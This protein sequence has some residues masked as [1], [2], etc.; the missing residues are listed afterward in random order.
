MNLYIEIKYTCHVKLEHLSIVTD[1]NF[2][3]TKKFD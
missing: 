3:M 2:K 1:P